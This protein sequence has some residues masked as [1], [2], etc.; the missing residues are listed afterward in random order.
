MRK[1]HVLIGTCCLIIALALIIRPFAV[2]GRGCGFYAPKGPFRILS[3][4]FH[5]DYKRYGAVGKDW[6]SSCT[7]EMPYTAVNAHALNHQGGTGDWPIVEFTVWFLG[8]MRSD[9]PRCTFEISGGGEVNA[10]K[11]VSRRHLKALAGPKVTDGRASLNA[12]SLQSDL[13][14][15]IRF[16]CTSE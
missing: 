16:N 2:Q 1:I 15:T 6:E 14:W 5:Y 8:P 9:N 4:E 12:A 10:V 13:P 11:E 7:R 3:G